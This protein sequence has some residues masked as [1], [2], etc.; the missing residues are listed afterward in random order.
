MEL[1]LLHIS[2]ADAHRDRCHPVKQSKI[3]IYSRHVGND[4]EILLSNSF[5]H[6]VP[7]EKHR[8]H[9]QFGRYGRDRRG[10]QV[11]DAG[12]A[13]SNFSRGFLNRFIAIFIRNSVRN[14]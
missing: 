2:H 11:E 5:A 8:N 9:A 7:H 4:H 6:N 3:A 12:A 14:I 10:E 13:R 1:L